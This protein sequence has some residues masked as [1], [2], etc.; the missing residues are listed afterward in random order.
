MKFPFHVTLLTLILGLLIL[1]GTAIGV[2]YHRNNRHT[3]ENLSQQVLGQT[4]K[5]IDEQ[6]NSLLF[7]AIEQCELNR[8]L[9]ELRQPRPADF[10]R[11]ATYWVKVLQQHH[12]FTYFGFTLAETGEGWYVKRD[13]KGELLV[14]ESRWDKQ[15]GQLEVREFAAAD[16]EDGKGARFSPDFTKDDPR[17]GEWYLPASKA[18]KQVWTETYMLPGRKGKPDRPGLTC[19]I[20]VKN[21]NGTL[22]GVLSLTFE[23]HHLCDFLKKMDIGEGGF[24]F[25][26]EYK[27]DDNHT[28]SVIAHPDPAIL[29][30]TV[31]D[32]SGK[33][34]TRL[35]AAEAI[36]DPLIRSFLGALQQQH[37][38]LLPSA[39]KEKT[40]AELQDLA[41]IRFTHNDIPYRGTFRCLS[42]KETP[43]WL[44]CVVVPE[45]AILGQVEKSIRQ[46][47]FIVLGIGFGAVLVSLLVAL[48]VAR[49]LRRLARQTA[50]IGQFHL[51]AEPVPY[52]IV[53]E[54]D[55]LGVAME[56]MKRS[57]RSFRKY[58]PAEVIRAMLA[59]GRDA[60]LGGELRTITIYFSDIADFTSISEQLTP[61]QIVTQLAEYF[62]AQSSQILETRGTVDKYIGDAIMAFWGAPVATSLHALAACTAAVRNQEIVRNLCK[63]WQAENKPPFLTRI[64]LNT[65]EVIVG[66]IGSEARLNYTVIGDPVNLASRLE[67]LNKYY[68]SEI[69][70]SESTYL[71]AK[72]GVVARP[73]DWVSVKGKTAGVL[74][75]ELLGLTG[76][77]SPSIEELVDAYSQALTSYRN[78]DWTRAIDLFEQVLQIRPHDYPAQLDDQA[79]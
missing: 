23:L 52:S 76:E 32:S 9:L 46:T 71:A 2:T 20:P 56:N 75:Y 79:L 25:I 60:S 44:I 41:R 65:G 37:P 45:R 77:V 67:G 1:T 29:L 39:L 21:P 18:E 22:R 43:D 7:T 16:Y 19:A 63:K 69:L 31:T 50:A 4:E 66:N 33:S 13:A 68:G 5:R 62:G 47:V 14:V 15:K 64:G 59:A 11:F 38:H 74:V 51:A 12:Y 61:E 72:E 53:K 58:V 3:I 49:P 54:V 10:P 70:I 36:G 35:V 48:Q 17:L 57:L 30:D 42:T 8:D 40:E 34:H 73:L 27:T 55:R 26:V 78:Q 24:P 6:V 28:R